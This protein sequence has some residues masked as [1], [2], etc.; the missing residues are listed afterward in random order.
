M[1]SFNDDTSNGWHFASEEDTVGGGCSRKRKRQ[2]PIIESHAIIGQSTHYHSTEYEDQGKCNEKVFVA[3]QQSLALNQGVP[4]VRQQTTLN[5]HVQHAQP[6]HSAF[7][8]TT[9][10]IFKADCNHVYSGKV[11][12]DQ[13]CFGMVCILNSCC[14]SPL[15]IAECWLTCI[16]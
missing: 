10:K 8:H 1:V 14:F 5:A 2:E 11:N 16:A 3:A 7:V 6:P 15:V 4:D 12:V 9:T 13:V